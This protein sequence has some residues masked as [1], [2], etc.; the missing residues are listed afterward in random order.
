MHGMT[1]S[2]MSDAARRWKWGIGVTV[3]LFIAA[4]AGTMTLS[5]RNGTRVVDVDYYDHGLHYGT[6]RNTDRTGA[7]NGW[8]AAVTYA[9][10]RL[11]L[12]LNDATGAPVRGAR[13]TF[14]TAAAA[15]RAVVVPFVEDGAGSYATPPLTGSGAVN[16]NITAVRGTDSLRLRVAVI[17]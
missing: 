8:R 6:E 5:V 16:G 17:R 15:S 7:G 10:G 4:L 3:L 2:D 9:G 13:V 14:S 1:R 11:Q 12:Q